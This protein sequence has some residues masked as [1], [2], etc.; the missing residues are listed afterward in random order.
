VK[1]NA[2][3]KISVFCVIVLALVFSQRVVFAQ[4]S[5]SGTFYTLE[6]SLVDLK[7]EAQ[8][9][10]ERN[11]KLSIK[12]DNLRNRIPEL[13]SKLRKLKKDQKMVSENNIKIKGLYRDEEK[14]THLMEQKVEELRQRINRM[15]DAQE[16]ADDELE[17]RRRLK[18]VLKEKAESIRKETGDVE[19]SLK[20]KKD[21]V[22]DPYKEKKVELRRNIVTV[23]KDI[24]RKRSELEKVKRSIISPRKEL[25][26]VQELNLSL[27]AKEQKAQDNVEALLDER[28]GMNAKMFSLRKQENVRLDFINGEIGDVEQYMQ[29]L[30]QVISDG[31]TTHKTLKDKFKKEKSSYLKDMSGLKNERRLLEGQL[32]QLK[33]VRG[34]QQGLLSEVIKTKEVKGKKN[35]L[36]QKALD[37]KESGASLKEKIAKRQKDQVAIKNQIDMLKKEV[38]RL[39]K[40]VEGEQGSTASKTKRKMQEFKKMVK[41]EQNSLRSAKKKLASMQHTE[42]RNELENVEER[43]LSL[44]VKLQK[45]QDESKALRKEKEDINSSMVSSRKLKRGGLD[46]IDQNIMDIEEYIEE[47]NKVVSDGQEVN[48]TLATEFKQQ[49]VFYLQSKANLAKEKKLLETQ[50][51]N[52]KKVRGLQQTLL[53]KFVNT[54]GIK[55]KKE[56]LNSEMSDSEEDVYS[57]KEKITQRKK[58]QAAIKRKIALLENE[59][60]QLK[61]EVKV[62]SRVKSAK[63]LEKQRNKMMKDEKN[64]LKQAERKLSSSRKS[65]A[66]PKNKLSG[67]KEITQDLTKKAADLGKE[68]RDLETEGNRTMKE[69]HMRAGMEGRY[70]EQIDDKIKELELYHKELVSLLDVVQRKYDRKNLDIGNLKKE[71]KELSEHFRSLESEN[72]HLQ[73]DILILMLTRDRLVDQR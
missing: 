51:D 52:L 66:G 20:E 9:T 35:D 63:S 40:D 30:K 28:D 46:L 59:S 27:I 70:F 61:K 49:K 15:E 16:E 65:I 10:V 32:D 58:D 67:L 18:E 39:K 60:S 48:R 62:K 73:E 5:K 31:Q 24:V 57:L 19:S 23:K 71:R 56:N 45:F 1:R 13:Q 37:S 34:F 68:V 42:L 38:H 8:D 22:A 69:R 4:G 25:G 11:R 21:F 26:N 6:Q 55:G 50:L 3:I 41:G 7:E 12:I 64:N 72:N 43:Y 54:R 14:E 47:L 2:L 33:T 29:D 36:S 17:S 44:S 53:G